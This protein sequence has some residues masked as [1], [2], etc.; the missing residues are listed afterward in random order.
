MEIGL[1][2]RVRGGWTMRGSCENASRE[3]SEGRIRHR[4]TVDLLHSKANMLGGDDKILMKMHLENG[5]SFRQIARLTGV[6]E[7]NIARRIR[8][9][10]RLLM[11]G[12]YINCLRHR[13]RFDPTELDVARD[14]FLMGLSIRSVAARRGWTFYQARETLKKIQRVLQGKPIANMRTYA[15]DEAGGLKYGD[16]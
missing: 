16:I 6:S 12:Q 10:T 2:R 15:K 3:R 13:E 5:G 1:Y 9:M 7:A 11:K 14:Y 8:K 4:R